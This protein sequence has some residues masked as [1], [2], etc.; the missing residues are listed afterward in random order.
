MKLYTI[1][2]HSEHVAG[3]LNQ[4]TTIF[5]RR[6]LNIESLIVSASSVKGIHKHIITT[7]TDE[8]TIEKVVKQINRRIDVIQANYYTDEETIYREIALYKVPTQE[9]ISSNKI[10]ELLNKYNARILEVNEGYTVIQKTGTPEETQGLYEELAEIK[11]LQFVRSG[12]VAIIKGSV[13]KL[14]EYLAD[15]EEKYNRENNQ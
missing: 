7:Y 5:T 9:L 2:V 6:Q 3:L 14:S 12:R 8:D 11:I 13:E 15:R 4:I 10:E 1:N